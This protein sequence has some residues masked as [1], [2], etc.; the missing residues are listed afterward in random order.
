MIQA[1]IPA[2]SGRARRGPG[3]R[4][5]PTRDQAGS[6]VV[7]AVALAAVLAILAAGVAGRVIGAS[8]AVESSTERTEA[9]TLAEHALHATIGELGGGALAGD[10]RAR[11]S[12][13][14]TVTLPPEVLDRA[15]ASGGTLQVSI[16]ADG[17]DILVG[18]EV[19]VGRATSLASARVR[20][21]STADLAWLTEHRAQDPRMFG[22]AR[23]RCTVPPGH[24]GRDAGCVDGSVPPGPIDGP[25]H[26][27]EP[28]LLTSPLGP[29]AP[30]TVPGGLAGGATHRTEIV[31]PR[32]T[33]AVL[34]E[35]PVTCRFRGPTLLRFDGPRVRVR[36]PRSVPRPDDPTTPD[37]QLGCMGVDR[38]LLVDTVVLTLPATAVIEVVRD[39]R[40]DCAAH[41]LGLA[42]GEDAGRDWQCD[43]GD[44]FVWGR[45]L[46][47]RTVLAE[48][49]IQ[50]VWDVEPG[51]ASAAVEPSGTDVLGLVAGDSVVLRRPV[52][53]ATRRDPLGPNIA[54][55][56]PSIPPFG[57]FPLDAPTATPSTWSEPRVVAALAALRGS[58]AVQNPEVG[59]PHHGDLVVL[60]SLGSRFA[61]LLGW[62]H[63]DAGGGLVM[64]TGY[65][66]DLRYDPRLD[67]HPPP[68]MPMTD[69]GAVRILELDVG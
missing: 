28:P 43:G 17:E 37:R 15:A 66:T 6:A 68:A 64:V 23:S 35:S 52:G 60:G 5:S 54:F 33:R 59:Q 56:G 47:A 4:R 16:A 42:P 11:R 32:T 22:L 55:A 58:V 40:S 8:V 65:R 14:S 27:N 20:P 53:R 21:R 50:V 67:R 57:A 49:S 34:G 26:S 18:V 30:L 69:G 13:P 19:I 41:P 29:I 12:L 24:P 31:L 36:S 44:A 2:G 1:S 39:E 48:D 3:P 61:P 38:T 25:V 63:R 51:D 45:Y 46:G 9:R 10:L 62:E 7:A